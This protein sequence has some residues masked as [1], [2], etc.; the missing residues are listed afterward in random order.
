MATPEENFEKI[1]RIIS[2]LFI[3]LNNGQCADTAYRM[4]S[5]EPFPKE[6]RAVIEPQKPLRKYGKIE[7]VYLEEKNAVEIFA[8]STDAEAFARII[9]TTL[10]TQNVKCAITLILSDHYK[11]APMKHEIIFPKPVFHPGLNIT[12]R[13][14]KKW[15][16]AEVGEL[17]D[18]LRPEEDWV[19]LTAIV[20]GKAL[21]PFSF[22]PAEW[23]QN[24]HSGPCNID[25][26][27]E[28]MK[29]LYPD[30][31]RNSLVTVLF[32]LV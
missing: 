28:E 32:F 19:I 6:L 29:Q 11:G 1:L 15:M 4:M 26:L 13:N 25:R 27:Y 7:L 20:I 14:G 24:M 12:V 22:I 21:V 17:L 31:C 10:E 9:R 18:V 30:F 5:I 2:P 16:K 3:A 8:S 23:L